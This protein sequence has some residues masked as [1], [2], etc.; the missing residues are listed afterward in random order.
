MMGLSSCLAQIV[1]SVL[2]LA[3]IL[4]PASMCSAAES[5]SDK[6]VV[7]VHGAHL[8]AESWREVSEAL[9]IAGYKVLVVNL[10]GRGSDSRSAANV[11]LDSSARALCAA[12]VDQ[13]P[14]LTFVAHSQGG[15]V[16]NHALGLC[17]NVV[18]EKI[19]YLA[20]VAPLNDE[21]PFAMLSKADDEHYYRGVVYDE[22]SGLMKIHNAPAFVSAFSSLSLEANSAMGEAILQGSV[23]EPA[24]I[25]E[26]GVALDGERFAAIK[27]YYIYTRRDQIISPATQQRIVQKLGPIETADLDSGHLPMLTQPRAVADLVLVFLSR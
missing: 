22:A 20:A 3:V 18:V 5:A 4:L 6:S 12:I 7:L 24:A 13:G 14:S 1:R 8:T 15:A 10:P 17:S 16:V 21:K 19:I 23:D 26:G 9:R 27:K 2:L 11:T 25:G